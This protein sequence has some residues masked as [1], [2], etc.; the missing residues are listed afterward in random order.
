MGRV[1]DPGDFV[2]SLLL[3]PF[4]SPLLTTASGYLAPK[5]ATPT[6]QLESGRRCVGNEVRRSASLDHRRAI[7]SPCA[8]FLT[9]GPNQGKKSMSPSALL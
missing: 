8:C 1:R 3:Y 6:T 2:P 7:P 5:L 9:C 4:L